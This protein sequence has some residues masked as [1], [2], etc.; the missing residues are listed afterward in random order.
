MSNDLDVMNRQAIDAARV[1]M[2][3]FAWP[4]VALVVV[5]VVVAVANFC[6]FAIGVWPLWAAIPVYA[7]L[8]Y[9]GYT[10]LHEAVHDNISGGRPEWKW[11]N[12][13]CGYIGAQFI[14][15]MYASH[16]PEHLTHHRYTNQPG[17]DPD[18]LCSNM[19][20]GFWTCLLYV[21]RFL[22]AQNTF[23]LRE[24]RA[25]TTRAKAVYATELA[26]AVGWRVGFV[27][28]AGSAWP[29]A[30][31]LLVIGYALGAFFTA[32]WFAYRP[33]VPYKDTARYRTTSSFFMPWWM[34]PVRWF[35]LGQD[36]H[37]VHHLFPRVPFYRYRTLHRRIEPVM[38]AHGTL[39]IGI[40]NRQP[41]PIRQA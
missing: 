29:G 38:R 32:Y 33:H 16:R 40:F 20:R 17:Q 39:M 34:K 26:F 7:G 2:G 9:L 27:V 10:P 6:A 12:E 13:I 24:D 41:V 28:L 36:V 22:W 1:Y 5:L 25:T 18:Y 19:S 4:T 30:I 23:V 21:V 15:V 11:L 31:A 8:T 37:S 3:G 14:T 35:W